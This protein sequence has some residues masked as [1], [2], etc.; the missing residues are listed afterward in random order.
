MSTES[1]DILSRYKKIWSTKDSR[2]REITLRRLRLSEQSRV[3]EFTDNQLNRFNY[4]VVS[5]IQTIDGN[6]Y[7]FPKSL[8]DVH[9]VLDVLDQEGFAAAADLYLEA[10]DMKRRSS[11]VPPA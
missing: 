2:G 11:D 3:I 1:E 10:N 8:E 6:V 9:L 7:F 4:N 5:A